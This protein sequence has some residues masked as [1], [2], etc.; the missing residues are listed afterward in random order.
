[1]LNHIA[2]T[3]VTAFDQCKLTA[4]E[5][6]QGVG[7]ADLK[8]LDE[9]ISSSEHAALHDLLDV[10][11]LLRRTPAQP[12]KTGFIPLQSPPLEKLDCTVVLLA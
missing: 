1:M 8:L 5:R 10:P 11:P 4:E 9:L 3:N 6:G 7:R 12:T 2:L